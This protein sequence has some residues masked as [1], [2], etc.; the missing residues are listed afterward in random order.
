M[1]TS[2]PDVTV[3]IGFGAVLSSRWISGW[4]ESL[5]LHVTL[6]PTLI[7]MQF[8]RNGVS[9]SD[10]GTAIDSVENDK[11]ASWI[12]GT[13]TILLGVYRQP[14]GNT[15]EV[16]D[17]V[18]AMLPAIQAE[19]PPGVEIELLDG[20]RIQRQV[21][22]IVGPRER[23]VLQER[24]AHA[25][26]LDRRRHRPAVMEQG[27]DV[28]VGKQSAQTFEDLLTPAHAGEPVVDER[29]PHRLTGSRTRSALS[30]AFV[31]L[32]AIC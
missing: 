14:D 3:R 5:P 26:A 8:G 25:V 24:G 7:I 13:R 17:R 32:P 1:V 19:L 15:V 28:G 21:G 30:G 20:E 6:W 22:A 18:K 12:N 9:L 29:G 27:E 10:V 4:F 23:E 31:R 11:V 2:L 16:V